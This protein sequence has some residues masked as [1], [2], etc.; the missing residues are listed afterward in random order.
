MKRLTLIIIAL[1]LALNA[2]AQETFEKI[3]HSDMWYMD[4]MSSI[5]DGDGFIVNVR[6]SDPL[7]SF[8]STSLLRLAADGRTT[9]SVG[10]Q[11]P[12]G[13][14]ISVF[15]LIPDGDGTF[16]AAGMSYSENRRLTDIAVATYDRDL[17]MTECHVFKMDTVIVD[18]LSDLAHRAV[19]DPD[20]SIAIA[21]RVSVTDG[22]N[23]Y[24]LA[25][26]STDGKLQSFKTNLMFDDN[27]YYFMHDFFI[28]RTQPLEYGLTC[29]APDRQTMMVPM[30]YVYD[31][32]FNEIESRTLTSFQ[33]GDN[34]PYQTYYIG[35]GNPTKMLALNDSTF[36]T[37]TQLTYSNYTSIVRGAGVMRF[38]RD[39]VIDG[40]SFTR[41]V[42]GDS[43]ERTPYH[44][45]FYL[46]DEGLVGCATGHSK[47]WLYPDKFYIVRYDYD[48]NIVWQRVYRFTDRFID[49]YWICRTADGG[50]LI[51]GSTFKGECP[52][53]T[54]WYDLYLLKVNG[55][56]VVAANGEVIE[57]VPFL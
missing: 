17:N 26:V 55:D 56:G 25:R 53:G 44:A 5:D 33:C 41:A 35:T 20:G 50:S 28:M 7:G 51:A 19:R 57:A 1:I 34:M 48:L 18:G 4:G 27:P 14:P 6:C 42:E 39:F 11:T 45:A 21:G 37:F 32:D 9:D 23:G 24:F 43:Y 29:F 13:M 3:I 15:D 10:C 38:N 47:D 12:D 8:Y 16:R 30:L 54:E 49:P 22:Y 46:D 40:Y 52:S 36:Y 31:S 2:G